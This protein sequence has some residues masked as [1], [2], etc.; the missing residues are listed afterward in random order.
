MIVCGVD[1]G[2]TQTAVVLL[3]EGRHITAAFTRDNAAVLDWF[4]RNASTSMVAVFEQVEF[5][6]MAVGREVFET[7]F[8]TGRMYEAAANGPRARMPRREVKLHLCGVAR[9]KDAN[10]RQALIDRFGATKEEA[11][12]RKGAPGPLYGIKA[13][14][15]AALAVAVTWYDQRV[16]QGDDDGAEDPQAC[17]RPTGRTET[18]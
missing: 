17:S 2:T 14:E 15:F 10:I 4:T 3:A 13:H 5:M 6:G 8:W 18:V 1:P 16:A 9:A 11:I 7:V 12:G